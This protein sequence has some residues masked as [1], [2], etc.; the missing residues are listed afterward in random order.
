AALAQH[1]LVQRE[2]AVEGATRV[3]MLETVREYGRERLEAAGEATAAASA[4]ATYFLALC[5]R[6][7]R[8]IRG[9]QQRSWMDRLTRELDNLHA[10]LRWSLENGAVETG[11]NL[12]VNLARFWDLRG[13]SIEALDWF[14]RLLSAAESAP[15]ALRARAFAHAGVLSRNVG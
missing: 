11:L 5:E 12:A 13:H 6:A 2:D 3:T 4:H 7:D 15:A 14:Q 1:S 10:A 9:A 8:G